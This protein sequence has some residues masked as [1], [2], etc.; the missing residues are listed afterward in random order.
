[1]GFSW[2]KLWKFIWHDDSVLSWI[3]DVI[4]AFVLV[5]FIIYPLLGMMLSTS[6]PIVAV[7]S[8]SMEHEGSFNDWWSQQSSWYEA[9]GFT[10][11]QVKSWKFHNGLNKGDIMVLRG[12]EFSKIEK[13]DI[14]VFNGNSDNP[15]IHRVVN[16]GDAGLST[17]GDNNADSFPAL[18]EVNI[19]KNRVLGIAV[20]RIPFLGW[21]KIWA[22]D[23]VKAII[24][25]N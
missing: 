15:I 25:G 4:I 8:N 3:F 2:K 11:E 24:G 16:I 21:I 9:N 6:Y 7:V 1:M 14:I 20:F 13:G 23:I 22:V 18:G 5:K 17:K 10:E 12:K 19:Q